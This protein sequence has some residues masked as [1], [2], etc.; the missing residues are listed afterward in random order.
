MR[1]AYKIVA[2]KLRGKRLFERLGVVGRVMSNGFSGNKVG[3]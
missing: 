1:S 2:G 3:S